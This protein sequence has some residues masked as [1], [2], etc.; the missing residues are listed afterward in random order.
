MISLAGAFLSLA[1]RISHDMDSGQVELKIR[2]DP[3]QRLGLN[4]RLSQ[5]V[6][7]TWSMSGLLAAAHP[8]P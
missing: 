6:D 5:A 4:F 2:A 7:E 3:D 8:D 1:H